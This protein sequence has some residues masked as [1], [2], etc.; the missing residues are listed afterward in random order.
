MQRAD[1]PPCCRNISDFNGLRAIASTM[2]EPFF[3]TIPAHDQFTESTAFRQI[4]MLASL[5]RGAGR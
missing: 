3:Q 2:F 1:L 4:G 5:D